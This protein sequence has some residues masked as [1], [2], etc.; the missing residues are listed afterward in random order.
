MA[1]GDLH[2]CGLSVGGQLWCSVL[3]LLDGTKAYI[4]AVIDNYSRK[5]LAWMVAPRLEPTGTC[6]LLFAAS[7]HIVCAGQ[8]PVYVDS[9]IENVN[10]AMDAALFTACLNRVLAQVDVGY[11]NSMI[12]AFWRSMKHQWLFINSLDSIAQL[13]YRCWRLQRRGYARISRAATITRSTSASVSL[14]AIGNETVR[15]PIAYALGNC[16][17]RKPQR[18]R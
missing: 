10:S 13:C 1:A 3:K 4:H 15:S 7:K 12:E 16:S 5:I 11:S 6:Q 2:T 17:G 9:G 14:G 8:P 18:S